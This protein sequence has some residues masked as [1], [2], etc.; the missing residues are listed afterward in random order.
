[1]VSQIAKAK[2]IAKVGTE[3]RGSVWDSRVA[4][5]RRASGLVLF[6]RM[7]LLSRPDT[8][9]GGVNNNENRKRKSQE[10]IK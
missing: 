6:Q 7:V 8:K 9:T 10:R 5:L 4:F 3:S 2:P 1:M